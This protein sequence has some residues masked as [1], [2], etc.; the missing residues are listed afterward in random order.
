MKDYVS[1]NAPVVEL[2]SEEDLALALNYLNPT[3]SNVD[4]RNMYKKGEA[5]QG[6]TRATSLYAVESG[7]RQSHRTGLTCMFYCGRL[8]LSPRSPCLLRGYFTF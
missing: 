3:L 5:D 7:D 4:V 1:M 8:L 2:L 6:S